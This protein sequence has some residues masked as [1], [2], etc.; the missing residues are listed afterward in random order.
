MLA[1]PLRVV[2]VCR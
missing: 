1:I 2:A